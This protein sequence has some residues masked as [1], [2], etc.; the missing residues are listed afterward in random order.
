LTR[1]AAAEVML[2]RACRCL[3]RET[4]A[5]GFSALQHLIALEPDEC[6]KLS[7]ILFHLQS[8]SRALSATCVSFQIAFRFN[9]MQYLKGDFYSAKCFIFR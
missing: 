5:M 1:A 7:S 6:D 2:S 8:D 3:L 9:G 4:C